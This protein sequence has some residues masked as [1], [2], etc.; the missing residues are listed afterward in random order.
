MRR[1]DADMDRSL[2]NIGDMLASIRRTE[3]A[4]WQSDREGHKLAM[5]P[6]AVDRLLASR[7]G[8]TRGAR[9]AIQRRLERALTV[10]NGRNPGTGWKALSRYRAE[11]DRLPRYASRVQP[12][13]RGDKA[14]RIAQQSRQRSEARWKLDLD[15]AL[16]S[17]IRRGL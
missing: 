2:R 15:D 11:L 4:I 8:M 6:S 1:I 13:G 17:D 7:S 16:R 9:R 14:A 5:S 10:A 12:F 3:R